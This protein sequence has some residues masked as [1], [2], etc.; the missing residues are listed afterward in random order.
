MAHI[1]S[2]EGNIGSGKSTLVEYFKQKYEFRTENMFGKKMI[3]MEEPVYIWETIKD[4]S[5]MNMIEKFYKNQE[6]YG[7]S[8]QMMAYISRVSMLKKCIRENPDSIIICERSIETDRN[9]FA[10]ML[11]H[12]GK[13]ED[14]NY[15]IYLKWFDEFISEIKTTGIIYVKAD[16][17]IS[18]NRVIKRDRKGETIPLEYLANCN[19]YHN[20]WLDNIKKEEILILN[21][22]FDKKDSD[23]DVWCDLIDYFIYVSINTIH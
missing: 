17:N 18:Y 11:Y 12:D 23:Y 20:D 10:K 13:I 14:V 3:F 5:G 9:V 16:P 7:F 8:F 2:I 1:F 15:Q 22:N 6:K 4:S 21:G 19:K